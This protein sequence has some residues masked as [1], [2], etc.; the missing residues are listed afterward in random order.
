LILIDGAHLTCADI[1]SVA[2]LEDEVTIVAEARDRVLK[3]H[4]LAERIAGER[5]V[6]GRTTGVGANRNVVVADKS[7]HALSL[8]RSHASSAGPLREPRRVRAM[9]VVRL[10]QLAAGGSGASLAVVDGLAAML[11]AD[12][13]PELREHSSIG[14][15]DL[16]DLATT[17]LALLGEAPTR[18]PLPVTVKFGEHDA[19]PFLSSNAA[20][21]GDAA[22]AC[23]ELRM[24]AR[25]YLVVAGLTFVAAKG[26]AEAFAEVVERVTPFDGAQ[27]VC[28]TM[29]LLTADAS[30]PTRIQDPFGLRTLPQVHGPALDA[31][32]HLDTVVSR[33]ANAPSENPVMLAGP[34]EG[35]FAHHGGFHAAYL[36]IALDTTV[37]ALAQSAQLVVA[38]LA[39]LMSPLLTG[40]PPFLGDG[41][42]GA[43]GVMMLEY[44]GAS[45]MGELR[46]IASPAGLQT[47]VLSRGFEEDAS[48]AWLAARQALGA[49]GQLRILL[50]CEL[51]AAVRAIRL[52]DIPAG[53]RLLSDAFAACAE[54]PANIDD[55]DLTE[56]IQIAQQVL[57]GLADIISDLSAF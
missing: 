9:L 38:R 7:T 54:L 5:A 28:R 23:T 21:I 52:L 37:I 10:N 11:A 57:P 3:S 33:L 13:L 22:L 16:T 26:N 31:L 2:H 56:D 8:L 27:Q 44:I 51:V 34:S 46:A 50:A 24:L 15:G 19:L 32:A 42:P 14:T 45:V 35:Q 48:F 20:T 1:A 55:R 30:P 40:L 29:R 41:T 12:A 4:Q 39:T 18:N 43:S 47:A 6:Y 53:S 25:A 36:G 17:A 49:A